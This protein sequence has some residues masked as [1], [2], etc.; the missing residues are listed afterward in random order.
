SKVSVSTANASGTATSA[1]GLRRKKELCFIRTQPF[2]EQS[3]RQTKIPAAKGAAGIQKA[4]CLADG[5]ALTNSQAQDSRNSHNASHQD[6]AGK[7]A[8]RL[9]DIGRGSHAGSGRG[10]R[11][12][13]MPVPVLVFVGGNLTMVVRTCGNRKGRRSRLAVHRCTAGNGIVRID[14]NAHIGQRDTVSS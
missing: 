8:G 5:G 6:N 3:M 7:I 10:R 1:A 9:D 2:R 4:L 12:I 13:N 14:R 11:F